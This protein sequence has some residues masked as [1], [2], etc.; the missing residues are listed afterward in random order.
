MRAYGSEGP[1][2]AICAAMFKGSCLKNRV[3]IA[4]LRADADLGLA[5]QGAGEA[6]YVAAANRSQGD[7][8]V[9][10][11]VLRIGTRRLDELPRRSAL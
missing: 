3:A 8:R 4:G 1:G 11:Q 7:T 10:F 2:K 6:V 9:L 5:A